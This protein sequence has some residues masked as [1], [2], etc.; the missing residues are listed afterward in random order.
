MQLLTEIRTVGDDC[1]HLNIVLKAIVFDAR[2]NSARIDQFYVRYCGNR[3]VRTV[4]ILCK[5]FND[6][7]RRAIGKKSISVAEASKN[8]LKKMMAAGIYAPKS[9][10]FI[11][12]I[13]SK[14]TLIEP[15]FPQNVVKWNRNAGAAAS[16]KGVYTYNSSPKAM[17]SN[18]RL[19]TTLTTTQ[20][21]N[22]EFISYVFTK[23]EG[24][25]ML[26]DC[27]VCFGSHCA[28][29]QILIP[30][31]MWKCGSNAKM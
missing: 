17:Y 23:R 9:Q 5:F 6:D 1:V 14:R 8:M 4:N 21:V 29:F 24:R 30:V 25:P 3:Y 10:S 19:T 11:G 2:E 22:F 18:R 13:D 16:C 12:D 31:K 15:E 7:I 27:F 26:E 20:Y 28:L